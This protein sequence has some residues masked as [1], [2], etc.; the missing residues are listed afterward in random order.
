MA[1]LKAG[2][3]NVTDYSIIGNDAK[4][5]LESIAKIFGDGKTQANYQRRNRRK[6]YGYHNRNHSSNTREK[7]GWL[8]G[9]FQKFDLPGN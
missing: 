8:R 6:P 2:G 7:N 9:T 4:V 3:N 1:C 5:I